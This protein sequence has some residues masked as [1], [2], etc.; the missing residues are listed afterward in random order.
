MCAK[1]RLALLIITINIFIGKVHIDIA[2]VG[3]NNKYTLNNKYIFITEMSGE[4]ARRWLVVVWVSAGRSIS[5]VLWARILT[6]A[7]G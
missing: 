6:E 7:P 1:I 3:L 2:I 5:K 4:G